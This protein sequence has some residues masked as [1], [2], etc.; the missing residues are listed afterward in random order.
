MNDKKK[1]EDLIKE[2]LMKV[3]EK[4]P[5]W[6]KCKTDDDIDILSQLEEHIWSKAEELAGGE[7]TIESVMSAIDHMGSP[8]NIAK[9]YKHRGT[10][11]FYITEELWP[12]Y[13]KSLIVAF[14]IIIFLNVAFII[15]NAIIGNIEG[16]W[17][18]FNIFLALG[19]AFILI[20]IIFV[21]LSMEGFLPEDFK[22][23][24]QIEKEKHQIEQ[25]KQEGMVISPKT[26]KPF[27]PI[28]KPGEKIFNGVAGLIFAVFLIILSFRTIVPSL[29]AD[30]AFIIRLIGILYAIDGGITISRGVLGN[31][32]ITGQQITLI[33]EASLKFAS[34]SV[35][36][37]ILMR[38]EIFQIFIVDNYV[39][40]CITLPKRYYDAFR[41]FWIVIILIQIASA[42]YNICK[43][44]NLAKY[45]VAK[46]IKIEV[47]QI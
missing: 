23:K 16:I 45:N 31:Q 21:G 11:K 3:E 30:F 4:L 29:N 8:T 42:I 47:K 35:L 5:E 22:S 46:T 25:A 12:F 39:L 36:I 20:T 2:F 13:K 7:P 1:M 15:Y 14:I 17:S 28:V 19:G 27:K 44:G 37:M 9:E 43:A 34:L 38:P 26:G 41:N 18:S 24:K 32:N 10:P 6:S 33:A 40:K